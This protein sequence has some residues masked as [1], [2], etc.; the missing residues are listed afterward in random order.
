MLKRT[1]T[2]D[3]KVNQKKTPAMVA[4][5]EIIDTVINSGVSARFIK[6]HIAPLA[7]KARKYASN[8]NSSEP[9]VLSFLKDELC[10]LINIK[11]PIDVEDRTIK[12]TTSQ[13]PRKA[14]GSKVIVFTGPAGSGKT[15]TLAKL[16]THTGLRMKKSLAIITVD[17]YRVAA[18]NQISTYSDIIGVPYEV[19]FNKS[20]MLRALEKFENCHYIFID[21]PNYCINNEMEM[22]ALAE[23][24]KIMASFKH[25][26][27]IVISACTKFKDLMKAVE[28]YSKAARPAGLIFTQIDNTESFD[29]I[30]AVGVESGL[31]IAYLCNGVQVPDDII[32]PRTEHIVDKLVKGEAKR[33]KLFS[34]N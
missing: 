16:A 23:F 32:I 11:A 29:E 12:M 17:T 34:F 10:K 2:T 15:T 33:G 6:K 7:A 27:Y 22:C 30:F 13:A 9:D 20:D 8:E 31:P 25:K 18:V 21:T 3:N 14:G 5:E 28:A 1:E 24:N 19:V 4:I 26:T